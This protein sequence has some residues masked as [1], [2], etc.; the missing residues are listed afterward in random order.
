MKT[1]FEPRKLMELAIEVMGQSV[2]EPRDDGKAS[3]KVGAVLLKPEGTV[4]TACRGE[5]R[6]GD[7]AEFTL[8]ERKNRGN[9]LDGSVLFATLEPCAPGARNE[10]KI[11]C[12]ER[13]VL[14]R[15]KEVWVGIQDPD[16][17]VARKGIEHMK[18]H[19][20]DVHMF[21]R[22]LQEI[23]EKENKEFLVQAMDRARA[24][25][26]K[27]TKKVILS[28]FE[29]T[30]AIAVT[31]D[32]SEEALTQYQTVAGLKEKVGSVAFNHRLVQQGFLT[33]KQGQ[34]IP[35]GF[36][37]LLFGKE[38][39]TVMPQAGLLA[40]IHYPDGT[41]ELRDFDEPLVLI[42]G[43]VEKWLGDKLPNIIDRSSMRRKET[44]PLP[45]EMIREAL[46]NA[47]IHR[48]YAIR[49]GKCQLV[50]TVDTI[51][52]KSPGGPIPPITLKQLQSF[53]APMLSRNPE[54]HYVFARMD[55]AEERGFGLRSLKN[56]AGQLALPLP[57]YTWKEPYLELTLFRT[58]EAIAHDL[59]EAVLSELNEDERP[60]WQFVA[61]KESITSRELMSNLGLD[62]RK[63]QRILKKLI[64][65]N[66]IRRVGGGPATR[67]E[68]IRS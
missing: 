12:A 5:L 56:L 49:E 45:F 62:E 48:D 64:G 31:D 55:M 60:A 6:Q 58:P 44:P 54:L 23:I 39:R 8:L 34:F 7:H 10:R 14:A 26:G 27:K 13:I 41:E 52:V 42:P 67:Y 36:G 66:L 17:K 35:T 3:P 15:I 22:D 24:D 57:K 40:T 32:F 20:I 43:A 50:V 47:L 25:K 65:V 11:D 63:A 4:E 28:T 19:G 46:V 33:Q 68:V 37:M 38:P 2:P 53:D 30:F 61:T 18:N 51:V 59:P 1:K 29:N 21:D 16:P 9:K